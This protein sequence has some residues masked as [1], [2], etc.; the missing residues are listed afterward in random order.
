M[1]Y[2]TVNERLALLESAI[3]SYEGLISSKYQIYLGHKNKIEYL[4]LIFLPS[5]F[6][7]LAGINKLKDISHIKNIKKASYREIKSSTQVRYRIINSSYFDQITSRLISIIKLTTNF[8]HYMSNNYFKFIH[9]IPNFYSSIKFDYL[10]KSSENSNYFHYFL[11]KIDE[12]NINNDYVL[13]STFIE[14]NKDYSLGQS[15]MSL[16]KKVF[17]NI[18]TNE[19]IVIYNKLD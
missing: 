4:Q 19:A 13:I 12:K 5:G 10:V 9:C 1:E 16:L 11:R 2:K 15:L 8:T 6:Y 17:V 3:N 7:H 14:N 18:L